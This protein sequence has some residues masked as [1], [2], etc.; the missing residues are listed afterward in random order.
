MAPP[1]HDGQEPDE[2]LPEL[3][4]KYPDDANFCPRGAPA[5]KVRGGWCPSRTSRRRVSRWHRR[6]VE[7][8]PAR[9]GGRR[10]RD[11]REVAY[12]LVAPA[13]AADPPALERA[14]RELKQLKRSQSPRIA[15]ILDAARRPT[16]GCSS[17][18][19]CA[20]A[21]PL[22]QSGRGRGRCRWIAPRR[23]SRRSAK[24]CS[25]GRR[26]A[27]STT[28]CRPRTSWSTANDEVKVINFTSPADDRPHL[29]RARVR[30]AR[31]G[32][33]QARR[34][35]LE[36]LQPG[37]DRGLPADRRSPRSRAPAPRPS[38]SRFCAAS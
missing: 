29:R 10:T 3:P 36:H 32:R 9:S 27:S 6:S 31:A 25:R 11:R 26:W 8:A 2:T 5:P 16:A 14:Q 24:R 19:S 22:E 30:V 7:L 15:R 33:G 20:T 1:G 21:R 34:S 4:D 37:R 18:A 12:K 38:W 17:P 28:T 35:A 13:V 23:S